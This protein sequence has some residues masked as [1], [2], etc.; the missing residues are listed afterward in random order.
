MDKIEVLKD[1][2]DQLYELGV[3][4]QKLSSLWE[5]NDWLNDTVSLEKIAPMSLDEWYMAIFA[6]VDKIRNPD[7]KV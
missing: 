3:V 5:D 1:V 4:V 6:K 7:I 2:A